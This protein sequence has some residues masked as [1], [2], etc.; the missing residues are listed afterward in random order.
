MSATTLGTIIGPLT[1][2]PTTA[3]LKPPI[4]SI[5]TDITNNG[6]VNYSPSNPLRIIPVSSNSAF[7]VDSN[8]NIF[9]PSKGVFK[10]TAF[11]QASVTSTTG[12][13]YVRCYNTTVTRCYGQNVVN[14]GN[15]PQMFANLS[16]EVNVT[17]T[18]VGIYFDVVSNAA[19]LTNV[20]LASGSITQ[21]YIQ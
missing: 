12:N 20:Q 7:R 19:T 3:I 5:Y 17:D 14:T 13:V 6:N 4:A 15:V 9:F 21:L 11:I 8:G 1:G 18:T 10:V 16:F 2:L